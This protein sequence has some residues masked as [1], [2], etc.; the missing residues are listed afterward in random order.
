MH[1]ISYIIIHTHCHIPPAN[2]NHTIN[3]APSNSGF[4]P[5][6]RKAAKRVVNPSAA[7]AIASNPSSSHNNPRTQCAG[8]TCHELNATTAANPNANHGTTSARPC[9]RCT[10]HDS[11]SKN[12]ANIITRIIFVVTATSATSA[13]IARPA[14]TTCATSCTLEPTY[15]PYAVPENGHQPYIAG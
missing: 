8:N 12:G 6:S 14:A 9:P 10:H 11:A 2:T 5:A 1:K 15:T 7:I 4:Q 13:P 3:N